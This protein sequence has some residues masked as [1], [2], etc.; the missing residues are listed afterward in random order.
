MSIR[1]FALLAVRGFGP[2]FFTR[3]LTRFLGLPWWARI[4]SAVAVT[5]LV[6]WLVARRGGGPPWGGRRAAA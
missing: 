1:L 4:A 6:V 3:L 2:R 5:L